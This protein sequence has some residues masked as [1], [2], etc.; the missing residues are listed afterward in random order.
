MSIAIARPAPSDADKKGELVARLLAAKESSGLTFDEI[1][2]K[3]GL[4][5]VYT[6][7]LFYNQAQLKKDTA[8]T[9]QKVVPGISAADLDAMQRAPMRSFD[10]NIIQE[11]LVYRLNEAVMHYGDALKAITNEQFGDGI[12]SAIDFYM[13]VDKIKG[14]QGEDRVV[15]TFNGKFLPHVEQRVANDTSRRSTGE[16]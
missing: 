14:K 2:D 16:A 4:T 1:A 11:P 7:Q 8:A 9:L 3:L 13:N 6:A 5:N 15:I 12:M 10:P